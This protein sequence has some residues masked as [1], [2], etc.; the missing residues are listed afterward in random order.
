MLNKKYTAILDM[1]VLDDESPRIIYAAIPV[2]NFAEAAAA[3]EEYCDSDLISVKIELLDTGL[4]TFGADVKQ[5]L[6]EENY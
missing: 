5:K 3:A 6:M 4:L 2:D 1:E